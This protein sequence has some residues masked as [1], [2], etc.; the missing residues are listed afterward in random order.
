MFWSLSFPWHYCLVHI[1]D[2]YYAIAIPDYLLLVLQTHP[3]QSC[4]MSSIDVH[5]HYSYQIMLPESIAIVMAPRDSSRK[6]GI[7]RLTSGGMT[8]IRQCPRRGFHSHD[9]PSD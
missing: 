9:P 8:V 4:F 6:H 2:A 3:T 5:T 1:K 7:F